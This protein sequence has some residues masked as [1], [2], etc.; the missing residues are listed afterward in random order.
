MK[1]R[2]V[3]TVTAVMVLVLLTT[4]F[5]G[6]LG[7]E[8]KPKSSPKLE[9][10]TETESHN[11]YLEDPQDGPG[12]NPSKVNFTIA[13]DVPDNGGIVAVTVT[14]TWTDDESPSDPDIFSASV[15]SGSERDE[16][17]EDSSGKIQLSIGMNQ[18]NGNSTDSEPTVM[19]KTAEIIVECV[20]CG[21]TSDIKNWGLIHLGHYDPGNPVSIQIEYTYLA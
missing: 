14:I 9:T 16:V 1:K 18:T 20:D 11:V 15:S 17:N 2:G 8:S 10:T 19:D 12:Q 13:P 3:L 5:T 7:G 6:C 21:F 4:T